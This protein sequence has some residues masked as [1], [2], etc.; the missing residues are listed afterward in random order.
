MNRD[1]GTCGT[2]SRRRKIQGRK[3]CAEI[4]EIAR[5]P[6]KDINLWIQSQQI[7]S[8][9]DIKKTMPRHIRSMAETKDKKK[10][11]KAVREK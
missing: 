11:L 10:S 9:T 2:I 7:L 4:T 8:R 5:N 6:V 3:K 1:S